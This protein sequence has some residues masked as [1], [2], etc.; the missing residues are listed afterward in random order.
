MIGGLGTRLVVWAIL[1]GV[2]MVFLFLF[3]LRNGR[4]GAPWHLLAVRTCLG[5]LLLSLSW[6]PLMLPIPLPAWL[7]ITLE[8][9]YGG[10]L[11]EPEYVA[12]L[13]RIAAASTAVAYLV[14]G[15]LGRMV[16]RGSG[17]SGRCSRYSDYD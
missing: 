9:A 1:L 8:I 16:R 4:R 15:V 6:M 12:P 5:S 10:S 17:A 2:P 14:G 11:A 13:P 7:F 3:G